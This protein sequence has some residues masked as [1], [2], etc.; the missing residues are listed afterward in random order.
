MGIKSAGSNLIIRRRIEGGIG[1]KCERYA[2]DTALQVIYQAKPHPVSDVDR[3]GSRPILN[4]MKS[5]DK[6]ACRSINTSGIVR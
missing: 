4:A 3:L 1:C 6:R 5:V 2:R